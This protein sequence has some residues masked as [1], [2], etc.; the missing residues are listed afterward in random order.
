VLLRTS[1]VHGRGLGGTLVLVGIDTGGTVVGTRVLAPRSFARI[2][3]AEWILE[4]APEDP[5]PE[6]GTELAIYARPCDWKT[7]SVR[8]PHRQPR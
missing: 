2:R 7:H 5:M 3:G 6:T 8:N 4:Q 1:S